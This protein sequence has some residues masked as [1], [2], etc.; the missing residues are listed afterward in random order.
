MWGKRG[1]CGD[2][3]KRHAGLEP[4]VDGEM[5]IDCA[6]VL[7]SAYGVGLTE[8]PH[9]FPLSYAS[10]CCLRLC[11]SIFLQLPAMDASARVTMKDAAKCDKHCELQ[12]SVNQQNFERTLRLWA[13][14]EGM[15]ASESPIYSFHQAMSG[16]GSML[17]AS[18]AKVLAHQEHQFV[19]R[20]PTRCSALR[21]LLGLA[22]GLLLAAV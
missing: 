19:R 3:I 14:P 5:S 4:G 17:C 18:A 21:L 2:R 6:A 16:L 8:P 15:S 22:G 1:A 13:T 11:A 10:I 7:A 20:T 12:N 9:F